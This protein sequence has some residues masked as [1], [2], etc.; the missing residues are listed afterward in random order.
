[1]KKLL[2]QFLLTLGT[3]QSIQKTSPYSPNVKYVPHLIK[4]TVFL[5]SR[6]YFLLTICIVFLYAN[7]MCKEIASEL[8]NMT[9]EMDEICKEIAVLNDFPVKD[10]YF[11]MGELNIPALNI[12]RKVNLSPL[13]KYKDPTFF[14]I[15]SYSGPAIDWI[16]MQRLI[17][18]IRILKIENTSSISMDYSFLEG[19]TNLK[20]L[21]LYNVKKEEL[22]TIPNNNYLKVILLYGDTPY[23]YSL[24]DFHYSFGNIT[25]CRIANIKVKRNDDLNRQFCNLR[26]LGFV[27]DISKDL[28]SPLTLPNVRTI[29]MF[30]VLINDTFPCEQIFQL[31]NVLLQLNDCIITSQQVFHEIIGKDRTSMFSCTFASDGVM[32]YFW[33]YEK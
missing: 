3:E 8:F 9:E 11:L 2:V 15:F 25:E 26:S 28:L 5:G 29:S 14:S 30:G 10:V 20:S 27:S 17:K 4:H 23:E 12:Q 6:L 19:A 24:S 13:E 32:K 22:K 16:N 21:Q 31:N 7:V 18:Y 1:M 33:K